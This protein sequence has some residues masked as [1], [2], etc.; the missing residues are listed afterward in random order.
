MITIND[1]NKRPYLERGT[2]IQ[3]VILICT[4]FRVAN[5]RFER[6]IVELEPVMTNRAIPGTELS[7]CF[8]FEG[9]E[10]MRNAQKGD[11]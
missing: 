1:Y 6:L 3:G 9:N 10:E 5:V 2:T 7:T 8:N 11:E 4:Q